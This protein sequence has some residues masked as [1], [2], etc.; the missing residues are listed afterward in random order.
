MSKIQLWSS[1]NRTEKL[2][3]H[4]STMNAFLSPNGSEFGLT[5]FN[6]DCSPI[7]LVYLAIESLN[8]DELWPSYGKNTVMEP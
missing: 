2:S 3:K 8:S 6:E 7:S 1:K 5:Y 4:N